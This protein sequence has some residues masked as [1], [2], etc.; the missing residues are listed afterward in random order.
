MA[1]AP[2]V[3]ARL[4][5]AARI[6]H[7]VGEMRTISIALAVLAALAPLVACG[8]GSSAAAPTTA[9][10]SSP[11]LQ[12]HGERLLQ[13]D[14]VARF[15]R[16]RDGRLAWTRSGAVDE[17]AEAIAAIADD[18]LSPADYHQRAIAALIRDRDRDRNRAA[19]PALDADL[20]LLVT[21]AVAALLDHVRYGKV[22]PVELDSQW[23]VDPREGA[24]PLERLVADVAA[25][26]SPRDAIDAAKPQH[27]IYRGLV[28]ALADLRRIARDGGWGRIASG[29]TIEPGAR[30]RRIPA[31]RRRLGLGGDL[32]S[33]ASAGSGTRYD[34]TLVAAVKQFQ[35]RHRL[36]ASGRV[37][38]DTIAELNVSASDR[39]DQ[40]RVNLERARWVLQDLGA[41]FVLVNL[42]AFKAYLIRGG[43]RVWESRTMIGKEARRSPTFRATL[44][45]IVLNPDWT[46]PHTILAEDVI[47]GMRRGR[48]V[49]TD[50]GLVVL[51]ADNR[52]VDPASIDWHAA[53]ADR[54][55][56]VVRQPPGPDN[57]LGRI[58][59]ELPNAYAIYMHDTPSKQLFDLPTRAMSSGCIR[60]ERPFELAALLLRGQDGWTA[61]TLQT[62]VNTG[63]T[64]RAELDHPLPVLVVYW[65]V[66]VASGASGEIRYARDVYELDPPLLAALDR[67]VP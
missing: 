31:L 62:A 11:D 40:V 19:R 55:P 16:A 28:D 26:A 54:F 17:I 29:R 59:F 23:N 65:T 63:V 2:A 44:R 48:D 21:D 67:R 34:P 33:S 7:F 64:R 8:P 37:D 18:G 61:A 56:Y 22:R 20:D 32:A 36:D 58:K 15:Y 38:P 27:F 43:K 52:P 24:P 13:P 1:V 50:H 66:S 6:L 25:A 9:A 5:P 53:S 57:V 46:V 41:D 49:L 30:D 51:D 10:P 4:S 12:V 60:L 35:G 39:A 42:P 14:V 47:A 3:T 45:S